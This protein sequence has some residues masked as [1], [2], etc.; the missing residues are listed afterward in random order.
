M[1]VILRHHLRKNCC[2]LQGDSSG[3]LPLGKSS[4]EP[5]LIFRYPGAKSKFLPIFR[6]EFYPSLK[7]TFTDVFVGGGSVLLD[8][9]EHFPDIKLHANDLNEN[10]FSFWKLVSGEQPL[11]SFFQLLDQKPTIELFYHLK[12]TPPISLEDFAY[13]GIFFNRTTFSG[14]ETAGPIGGRLQKSQWTIDCRYNAAKLKTEILK[15]RALLKGRT[16]VTNINASVSLDA[17]NGFLYLDPPYYVKGDQLYRYKMD[18]EAHSR[19]AS[20]LKSIPSWV[21]SYDSCPEIEKLYADFSIEY[22][23]ARYS[24]N[25]S[26]TTW[27]KSSEVLIRPQEA[28]CK[29]PRC[30]A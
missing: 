9:A 28:D 19:L 23:D 30:G 29:L 5:G 2:L 1:V 4:G 16:V 13:R 22:L 11:D 17:F 8:V 12:D 10:I 15:A 24:I 25:G 21:L 26:K 3:N 27:A 14:I 20:L 7:D 6:R 18:K